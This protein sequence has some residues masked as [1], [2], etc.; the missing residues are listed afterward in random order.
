MSKPTLTT[1]ERETLNKAMDII[2]AHTPEGASFLIDARH[3]KG[4]RQDFGVCY[5]TSKVH[6]QHSFITGETFADRIQFAID[7]ETDERGDPERANAQRIAQ[8][9]KQLAE[10][11]GEAA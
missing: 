3:P 5:F 9:R 7:R 8:L 6:T 4:F 2:L 1:A 10:L 11:T